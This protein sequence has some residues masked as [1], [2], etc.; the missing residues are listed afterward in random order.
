MKMRQALIDS[1][2]FVYN[3]LKLIFKFANEMH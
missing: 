1:N 2:D 3:S